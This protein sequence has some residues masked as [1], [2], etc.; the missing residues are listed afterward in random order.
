M[1]TS[2]DKPPSEPWQRRIEDIWIDR[3][4]PMDPGNDEDIRFM[5]GSE[6]GWVGVAPPGT[7]LSDEVHNDK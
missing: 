7:H 5:V 6:G 3:Q 4:Q 2:T 1:E